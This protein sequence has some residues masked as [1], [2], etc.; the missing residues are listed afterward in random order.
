M[1]TN[2]VRETLKIWISLDDEERGLREKIKKLKQRKSD[3]S[4]SILEFMRKNE[5]DN[6]SLEGNGV[7]NITRSVRTSRPPLKRAQLRTQLLL[8]FADQ[9]QK[10]GE[11][12]RQI[13]GIPDNAENMSVGGTQKELLVRRLPRRSLNLDM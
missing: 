13:E 7:G 10:V 4:N 5:V 6:F 12:L 2:E 1:E 9:P 11:F 8:H 3:L